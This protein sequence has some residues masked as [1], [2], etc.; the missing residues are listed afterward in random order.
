VTRYLSKGIAYEV[1]CPPLHPVGEYADM[2]LAGSLNSSLKVAGQLALRPAD[3]A[4]AR[5]AL[6]D[7]DN[8][9]ADLDV[10]PSAVA[11]LCFEVDVEV[12][13][14]EAEIAVEEQLVDLGLQRGFATWTGAISQ[15][16]HNRA[17]RIREAL[18]RLVI[19]RRAAWC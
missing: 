8:R 9:E 13:V 5:K 11:D 17:Q 3:A 7:L 10:Y 4:G 1:V 14:T 18:V 12:V 6:L 15:S 19:L 16:D 2:A